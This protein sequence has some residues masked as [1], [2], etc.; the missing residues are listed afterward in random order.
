MPGMD[1][2]QLLKMMTEREA[3]D[4]FLSVDSVPKMRVNGALQDMT[5]EVVTKEEMKRATNLLLIS[6]RKKKAYEEQLDVD[7]IHDEAGIGRF[8]INFFPSPTSRR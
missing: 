4:L 5:S 2:R 6:E 1:I 3:S 7:F 8:R